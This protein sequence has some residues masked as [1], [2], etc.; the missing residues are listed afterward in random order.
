VTLDPQLR[1]ALELLPVMAFTATEQGDIDWVGE[2]WYE[3]T[4]ISRDAVL[5]E[6]WVHVV[7]PDDIE[8][9]VWRWTRALDTGSPWE[10]TPRV[11]HADGTYHLYFT[12]AERVENVPGGPRWIG[13]TIDLSALPWRKM[14][15]LDDDADT[16]A[17]ALDEGERLA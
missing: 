1:S 12:R 8:E 6:A 2:R 11:R 5:G 13:T 7:H 3:A 17:D 14:A 9:V 16:S 15:A 10:A 4:G